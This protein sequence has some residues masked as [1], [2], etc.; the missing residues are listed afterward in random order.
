MTLGVK[1]GLGWLMV[2][3]VMM[4]GCGGGG[5]GSNDGGAAPPP[6]ASYSAVQPPAAPAAEAVNAS[7]ASGVV[8]TSGDPMDPA[9]RL[10]GVTVEL[11]EVLPSGNVGPVVASA[12]TGAGGSFHIAMPAGASTADGRWLLTARPVGATIRAYVHSGA[13]KVDAGSEAWVRLV[14]FAAGRLLRF[15]GNAAATLKSVV[16]SVELFSGTQGLELAGMPVTDASASIVQALQRDRAMGYVV[17][18]LTTSSALPSGGVGDIGGFS[19]LSG[20]YAALFDD[21]GGVPTI[22]Q[23]QPAFGSV[24]AADGAWSFVETHHNVVNGTRGAAIVGVGGSRRATASRLLGTVPAS[25]VELTMLSNAIGEYPQRSLTLQAGDRQL[26]ARRITST[27]LN[28]TGGTDEQPISFSSIERVAGVETIDTTAGTI[29]VVRV[30]TEFEIAFPRS[31]TTAGRVTARSTLW[32]APRV[33]IVRALDQVLVDGVLD[34]STP[35]EFHYLRQAWAGDEVWLNRVSLR[36]NP[37]SAARLTLRCFTP[38]AGTRRFITVV[39]GPPNNGS[40]TLALE[41][42]DLDTGAQIGATRYFS[43]FASGCPV[44]AGDTGSVLVTETFF[45]RQAAVAWPAGQG[46]AQNASDVIHQ[47]DSIDLQDIRSYALA[48]VADSVQAGQYW[49]GLVRSVSGAPGMSGALIVGL[50]QYDSGDWSRQPLF[51]QVLQPGAAGPLVNLGRVQIVHA[52]WA[53]GRLFT[54]ENFGATTLRVTPFTTSGANAAG[55][56][57]VTTGF[58]DRQPWYA[59][60]DLLVMLDGTS[61]RVS[62]GANGPSLGFDSDKCGLGSGRLV[63][64][65][66]RNDRLLRI[67]P[68]TWAYHTVVPLGSYLRS[69]SVLGQDLSQQVNYLGGIHVRDDRTFMFGGFDVH[70]G[71]WWPD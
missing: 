45:D 2:A 11:T 20:T 22:V 29:R 17:S 41:L 15:E 6:S 21:R 32:L 4:S 42:R 24:M 63:C 33:G 19:A 38:L 43:G 48:P 14:E 69:L 53:G 66:W 56:Q 59:S 64:L 71:R 36:A 9:G 7:E 51:A 34:T 35:D 67:D 28:F 68:D 52:D 27:G 30:V 25:G 54:W 49:P 10:A 37:V 39:N 16:R 62:D 61:I 65:D 1:R 55:T 12:S 60:G 5:G 31:A 23:L 70:V 13:M 57:V 46:T 8:G 47:V 44:A 50:T 18:T 58:V 40:P 3:T 26:D